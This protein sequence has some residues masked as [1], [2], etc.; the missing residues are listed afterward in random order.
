MALGN[1]RESFAEC[2][3][4]VET[5]RALGTVAALRARWGAITGCCIPRAALG[6]E[7]EV[8]MKRKLR[9]LRLDRRTVRRL[10][11]ERLADVV[12][13]DL[14]RDT[15]HNSCHRNWE[16]TPPSLCQS[17]VDYPTVCC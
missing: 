13:G 11:P 3:R 15:F 9:R 5:A 17:C 1:A 10:S 2:R 14:N 16:T 12:G 4:A 6:T 7:E 8:S